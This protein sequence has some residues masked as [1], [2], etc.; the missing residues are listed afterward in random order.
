[1]E[2]SRFSGR[3]TRTDSSK[4]SGRRLS[5]AIS[6]RV[7][8]VQW[9]SDS[10]EGNSQECSPGEALAIGVNPAALLVEQW[11][12]C[13]VKQDIKTTPKTQR[14]AKR[15]QWI[16]SSGERFHDD[17]GMV[18]AVVNGFALERPLETGG[19]I[20]RSHPARGIAASGHGRE[21]PCGC[22]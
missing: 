5:T 1:M 18:I 14:L 9:D 19:A 7:S 22:C 2:S 17:F 8:Q 15:W 4:T 11:P 13:A 21:K 20:R 16:R 3:G 10:I 6:K 12:P